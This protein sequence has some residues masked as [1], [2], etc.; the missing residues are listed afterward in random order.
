M[1]IGLVNPYIGYFRGGAETNDTNMLKEFRN[2][3]HE[4]NLI[5]GLEPGRE[6]A[7]PLPPGTQSFPVT[8]WYEKATVTRG[9]L[10]KLL[11]HLYE[12]YFL[13]KLWQNRS[14][15]NHY[16]FLMLTGR[17]LLSKCKKFV[18]GRVIQS[19]RGL[20]NP[21]YFK[22]YRLADLA[23]FW[24]GCEEEHP[25]KVLDGVNFLCLDG[26]VESEYF[27]PPNL[28]DHVESKEITLIYVG[29]LDPVQGVAETLR[30]IHRLI[31]DGFTLKFYVVGDGTIREQI[32]SQV[33][34]A[35]L[36][37][38]VLFFGRQSREKTGELLRAADIFVLN[39]KIENHPL[40][41]KEAILC[42]TYVIGPALGRVPKLIDESGFGSCFKSQDEEEL[43]QTLKKVLYEK[44]Y[45]RK[46]RK[47]NI[48]VYSS[49]HE[50][51]KKVIH[52]V[53]FDLADSNKSYQ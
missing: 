33:K 50:N 20:P 26:A 43:L 7:G 18:K 30:V 52:R 16:D 37:E 24:G 48:P 13:F 23:I 36:E 42:G 47:S 6:K 41:M 17:P 25:P 44:A 15:L 5:T 10:G 28:S 35:G 9:I 1:K 34:E 31:T 14:L 12:Y 3:G 38:K 8:F 53:G 49:W 27:F 32:E 19:I 46:K 51:A 45:Q 39:S 2:L 22:Y 21:S 4:A 11:R 40:S 29:R